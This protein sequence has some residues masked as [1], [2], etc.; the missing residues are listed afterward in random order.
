MGE[1]EDDR[2]GPAG[3][4]NLSEDCQLGLSQAVNQMGSLLSARQKEA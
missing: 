3:E 2:V 4:L 1:I